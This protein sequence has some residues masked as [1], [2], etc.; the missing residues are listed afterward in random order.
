MLECP[1]I[2]THLK[3]VIHVQELDIGMVYGN[4][5]NQEINAKKCST[6]KDDEWKIEEQSLGGRNEMVFTNA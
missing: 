2:R 1:E 3:N 4:I 5:S 6:M